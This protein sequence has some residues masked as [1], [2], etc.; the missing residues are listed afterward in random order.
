L[1]SIFLLAAVSS[2]QA[3]NVTVFAWVDGNKV[4]VE[5]KFSGGRRPINAPVEVFDSA[6]NLLLSGKT[7]D[8]GTFVFQ[9]PR[10]TEMKVVLHA[11][12]GH[13]A[14]WIITAED[15]EG[16]DP[17]PAAGKSPPAA[18]VSPPPAASAASTDPSKADIEKAVEKVLD[19]KLKPVMKLL[20]ESRHAG[21][22][23][24][25]VLGGIGYIVGLMGL[26]AY[27][28]YRRSSKPSQTPEAGNPPPADG[29]Q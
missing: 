7:D 21:P 27:L 28:R 24:R 9:I 22:D 3:H 1:A 10:K 19:R 12:M 18:L 11:G 4:T 26:A 5:G 29:G 6:G 16:V 20:A 2:P 25:D 15:L 13:Q 17:L 23:L 14:Q 8:T